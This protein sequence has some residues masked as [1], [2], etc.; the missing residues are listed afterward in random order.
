VKLPWKRNAALPLSLSLEA[1]AAAV[2]H[3]ALSLTLKLERLLMMLHRHAALSL[4]AI[5]Q[6]QA[7]RR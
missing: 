4:K 2:D 3:A 6:V 1:R 5:P 7:A